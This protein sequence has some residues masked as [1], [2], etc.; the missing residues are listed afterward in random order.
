VNYEV[1][2]AREGRGGTVYYREGGQ[3]LP[4]YW[5]ITVDGFEVYVPTPDEWDEFC[6]KN[7]AD[8]CKNRR[9]EI[10]ER[11]AEEVRRKRAKSAVVTMDGMGIH[12]SF[13]GNW[14][15]SLL[16]RILGF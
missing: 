12:Y 5:D 6:R 4:F 2:V 14:L 9:Q 13:E 7:N 11:V 8:Q 10:L 3:T 1:K 16:R 15:Y